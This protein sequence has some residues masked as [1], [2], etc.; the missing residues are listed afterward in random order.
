MGKLVDSYR[1]T[2]VN[3]SIATNTYKAIHQTMLERVDFNS[4]ADGSEITDHK[5][6][7]TSIL[8]QKASPS[9]MNIV[10]YRSQVHSSYKST[11][12]GYGRLSYA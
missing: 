11:V 7:L 6:G 10:L 4:F 3:M 2:L 12:V 9:P 8:C 5:Q 1:K